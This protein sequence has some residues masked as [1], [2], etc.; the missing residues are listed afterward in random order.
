MR[1]KNIKLAGFKSFVD[2]TTIPMPSNMIGIV[3]PNGCGK[4]N[5]IDAVRWVMGESSAKNLRGDSMSDVIFNGSTARKPVGQASVELVF[6]NADGKLGGEYAHYAEISVKRQVTRDGQSGYFLNGTKC[7][8]RDITD[9]FLGTGLGPRSYAI[10]EQGTISRLIE[11][12]PEESAAHGT[13]SALAKLIHL[14]P[15]P[16]ARHAL[17]QADWV[18]GK[19]TDQWGISDTN[20]CLKLGFDAI[21]D[22]WPS[23][24]THLL[25][26]QDISPKLLP[27]VHSPGTA[28]GKISKQIA[29]QF[30]LNE[31]TQV[32]AGTT[33]STAAFIATGASKEG[34][35]VTSLGSTLVMKV[36]SS[37]PIFSPEHGV[38]AQPLGDKWLVGGGS[39]SGGAVLLHHFTKQ[40]M[41]NMTPQLQPEHPTGLDYYPLLQAGERFPVCDANLSPRM[42]PRPTDDIQY[43]QAMLEGM[44]EIELKSYRLLESLGAPYPHTVRSAGGGSQNSAWTKIRRQKLNTRLE[45]AQHQEAAYGSALLARKG[46]LAAR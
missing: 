15:G 8:R 9:I 7:R 16:E 22:C 36:I 43:F 11:A 21:D 29:E 27:K 42:T 45:A 23:W 33:D 12:K 37:A 38:Y 26:A 17:H 44:A 18:V 39:N 34:E 41:A 19:L 1:L 28:I 14:K 31:D 6:E 25:K 40:Q 24:L 20:N 5:T 46:Y 3:G 10:I 32:V 2:P 13:S 35:A 30:G 4:S